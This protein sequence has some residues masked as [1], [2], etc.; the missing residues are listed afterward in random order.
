M[1]ESSLLKVSVQSCCA[2]TSQ[3]MKKLKRTVVFADLLQKISKEYKKY[4]Y[5]SLKKYNRPKNNKCQTLEIIAT[6]E[7][8]K[9]FAQ[10]ARDKNLP[11]S[12][13]RYILKKK[14]EIRNVG[15]IRA[16]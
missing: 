2:V 3:F 15:L 5:K 8:G 9:S 16:L 1:I 14:D 6:I 12:T 4:M 11:E 13:V 10:M 7:S